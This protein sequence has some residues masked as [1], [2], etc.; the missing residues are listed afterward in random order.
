VTPYSSDIGQNGRC[1]FSFLLALLASVSTGGCYASTECTAADTTHSC[2]LKKHRLDPWFCDGLEGAEEATNFRAA[3]TLTQQGSALS[4]KEVAAITGAAAGGA[5]LIL[6]QG[7]DDKLDELQD[8]L[9]PLMEE[10]ARRAEQTVNRLRLGGKILGPDECN[11]K[12]GVDKDGKP[13]TRAM[14]LGNE[15]HEKAFACVEETLGRSLPGYF[16]INQRYRF[17]SKTRQYET[18]SKEEVERLVRTDRTKELTGS[19]EPDVVIH[20]GNPTHIRFIYDFKFPC[21][22][23]KLPTWRAYSRGPHRDQ[24]QGGAYQKAFGVKPARVSPRD[25]VVR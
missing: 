6:I 14:A 3:S 10:C 4:A 8:E 24:T 9:D 17:N 11:E 23:D 2:C 5:I 13:V 1:A 25:G 20:S 21:T 15:K 18:I 22:Q 7:N 19:L 12:V 16:I